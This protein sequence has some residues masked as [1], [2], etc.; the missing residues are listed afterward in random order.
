[1]VYGYVRIFRSYQIIEHQISNILLY[2]PTA[3]IVQEEYAKNKL[4]YPNLKKLYE[5]VRYGDTIIFD[6]VSIMSNSVDEGVIKYFELYE[7]GINLIFLNEHHIDT[8]IYRNTIDYVVSEFDNNIGDIYIESTRRAIEILA[9]RQVIQAFEQAEKEME[10]LRN[11]TKEGI[12]IARENGK[13]IGQQKGRKLR[14][15][16]EVPS[17]EEIRK[18]SKDFEGTLSDVECMKLINISRNTYYKYK[19]ELKE[20]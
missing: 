10:N 6:S 4:G 7:K 12:K 15:K 20:L 3:N 16:K 9:K 14:V 13:Q 2:D 1:M 17:K 5:E 18:Y 11:R 19:K 8:D